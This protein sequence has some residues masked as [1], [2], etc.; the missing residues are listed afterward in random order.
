MNTGRKQFLL[1]GYPWV[2]IT[3]AA[4]FLFYKYVLQVSP[5]VMT[6]D[7][8]QHFHINGTGLGN[9]A[10]TFFYAYLVVQLFVGPLL[11]KYNPRLLTALALLVSGVG[12]F[13]FAESQTLFEASI[14]RGLVGVGAA[15]ATVS[16]MKMAAVWFEPR[17]FAFVGGLLA[18]AAMIGSMAGQLPLAYLVSSVG[19]Q[20]ALLYCGLLGLALSSSYY[21]VVRNKTPDPTIPA[22]KAITLDSPTLKNCLSLLKK[23]HNWLLMFYSGLAFSPLAVFGGLWGN[24]FLQEDFHLTKSGAAS[25]VTCAFMGL[26]L[27]APLLG[28]L[29]DRLGKRFGVMLFG[30]L[31]SFFSLA[32]AVYLP[33][34]SVWLEGF[35][36]FLFGFGTGA[37]MLGFAM[38]K[39]MNAVGLAASVIALINT[40]DAVF[41]AFSEPLAGKVLDLFWDG[42]VVNGVHYFSLHDYHL[43]LLMLPAYLLLAIVFLSFLKRPS[44]VKNPDAVFVT[45]SD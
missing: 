25:L 20:S 31:L 19:W 42:K 45:A 30:L 24:P 9:L 7:L 35:L 23:K 44:K 18:T 4:L 22:T 43:A 5:S 14:A 8:M 26:A 28:F 11:D 6:N 36:L 39:E 34:I 13:W 15:F 16:Y 10:A 41:G 37:F 40:G 17:Q 33:A 3:F 12:A 32:L 29:S 27:G 1:R 2:V 21:L 38:G